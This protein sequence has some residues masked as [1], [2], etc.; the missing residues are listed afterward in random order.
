MSLTFDRNGVCSGCTTHDEKYSLD[1]ND[2]SNKL[3]KIANVYR[4]KNATYDCIIPVNS[5]SDSYYTVYYVKYVLHLKPLCVQYNS[6]YT[7]RVG[8]RNLANLEVS[9]MSIFIHLFHQWSKYGKLTA[10]LCTFSIQFIGMSMPVQALPVQIAKKYNI[11][12]IIWLS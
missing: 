3:Q 2:R 1:W 4:A 8:H 7:N 11:P 10:P 12:L 5:G 9:L 6:L